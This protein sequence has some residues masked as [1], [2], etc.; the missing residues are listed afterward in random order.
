MSTRKAITR[1]IA[2]GPDTPPPRRDPAAEGLGFVD[3]FRNGFVERYWRRPA[4]TWVEAGSRISVTQ[5]TGGAL[6]S[7]SIITAADRYEHCDLLLSIAAKATAGGLRTVSLVARVSSI[8]PDPLTGYLFSVNTETGSWVVW[9]MENGVSTPLDLGNLGG[10]QN[11][12]AT[13]RMRITPTNQVVGEWNGVEIFNVADA[14]T[15]PLGAAGF[16]TE[17]TGWEF[18]AFECEAL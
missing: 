3:R 5:T 16:G 14:V 4:G 8:Y 17:G 15:L 6:P 10:V 12:P 18:D 7:A 13:M 11:A 9:R 2:Q 1:G